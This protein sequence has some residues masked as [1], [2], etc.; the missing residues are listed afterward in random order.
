MQDN[1]EKLSILLD[2]I[3]YISKAPNGTIHIRY[4]N[5]VVTSSP[6]NIAFIADENFIIES[7]SLFLNC[8]SKFRKFFKSKLDAFRALDKPSFIK[9]LSVAPESACENEL[10]KMNIPQELIKVRKDG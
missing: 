5:N 4:K 9:S 8:L 1:A 2:S 6:K 7:E 10:L 3:E